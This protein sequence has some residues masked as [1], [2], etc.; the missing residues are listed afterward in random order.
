MGRWWGGG[1]GG[2]DESRD[3]LL[4]IRNDPGDR[5]LFFGSVKWQLGRL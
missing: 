4:F 1:E 3:A 5:F 2:F